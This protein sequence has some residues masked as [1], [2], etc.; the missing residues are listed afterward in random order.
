MAMNPVLIRAIGRIHGALYKLT[1]GA[2]GG[3]LAGKPM[4]LLTTTGRK[5]GKSRTTPLQYLEDGQNMVIVAS[6]G[7]NPRHP[8]L[9]HNLESHPEAEAQVG[10]VTRRVRAE[11]ASAEE[12]SRLWPLLVETT[13]AYEEYQKGTERTIPVVILRPAG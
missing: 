11:T 13:P 2:L 12:R 10:K 7:G 6:N 9:W 3:R 5:T 8:A 1:A 4:L